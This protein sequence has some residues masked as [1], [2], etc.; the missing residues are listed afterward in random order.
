MDGFEAII[1]VNPW[2]AL[3]TLLNM[4]ITFYI[5]K[6]LL[7]GP[8]KKMIDSRKAEVDDAYAR[9]DQARQEASE[10]QDK[11]NRL[12]DGAKAERDGIIREA[13]SRAEKREAEII[14]EAKASAA[15]I[16]AK[17]QSDIRQ[18][19]KKALNEVKNQISGISLEIAGK[20]CEKEIDGDKYQSLVDEFISNIGEAS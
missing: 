3:F 4:L 14:S 15:D 18:E 20:V 8:V 11:Y 17:A 16:R 19:K 10:L 5:L 6:K 1:G 9:A 7:F 13:V 2:T 12:M